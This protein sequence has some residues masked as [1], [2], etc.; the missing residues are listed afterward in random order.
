M[1]SY[2]AIRKRLGLLS[3]RQQS[4]TIDTIRDAMVT[5]RKRF[6]KA[7]A[8]DMKSLLFHQMGMSVPRC[9]SNLILVDHQLNLVD[10]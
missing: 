9:D 5:L 3:T 7:G 10:S 1:T 8:H 4:H 6:P 2:K